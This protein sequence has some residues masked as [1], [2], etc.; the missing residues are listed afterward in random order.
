MVNLDQKLVLINKSFKAAKLGVAIRRRCNRYTVR[1]TLPPRPGSGK[2]KSYQQDLST[3]FRVHPA[4]LKAAEKLAKKIAGEI[5]GKTFSW[6]NYGVFPVCTQR[7]VGE[8]IRDFEIAYYQR[9]SRD[10]TSEESFKSYYARHWKSLP[11]DKVLTT[12]L[13]KKA[14]L[15]TEANSGK[16]SKICAACKALGEFAQLD[17]GFIK[18]LKGSYS[19]L[20]PA[21]R[22]LPPDQE[23]ESVVLSIT[24]D[25]LR[26]A[27]GM[28]ATYGLR[29]HEVFYLDLTQWPRVRVLDGKTGPRDVWAFRPEWVEKFD[30][31]TPKVPKMSGDTNSQLGSRLAAV[32][33]KNGV[34]FK[35]Y[36]LRHAWAVRTLVY[37]IPIKTAADWMGHNVEIHIKVYHAWINRE[38][39]EAIY[40]KAI[41]SHG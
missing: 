20:K 19:S 27:I 41:T 15:E 35:L 5:A 2:T 23:I 11:Q 32:L 31:R 39:E 7:T 25:S 16:R 6:S 24:D 28:I 21:P 13:L 4:G 36:N 10:K 22:V 8:W 18:E 3:G 34:P 29:P 14:I 33:K 26:W 40:N 12:D 17:V 37:N 1:A 30:L 9:R 38:I